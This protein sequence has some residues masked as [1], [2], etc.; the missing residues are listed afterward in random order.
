MSKPQWQPINTA[1]KG[2]K[3]SIDK[4][5]TMNFPESCSDDEYDAYMGDPEEEC[6]ND[7]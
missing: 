7:D 4:S 5:V 3:V 6:T 2:T 1:P